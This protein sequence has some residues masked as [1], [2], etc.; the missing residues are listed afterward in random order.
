MVRRV[1]RS[2]PGR[3]RVTAAMRPVVLYSRPGWSW[4]RGSGNLARMRNGFEDELADR[5]ALELSILDD[6][7]IS[8][9]DVLGALAATGLKLVVDDDDEAS[10]AYDEDQVP[11]KA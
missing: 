3:G 10:V 9:M 1:A 7:K 2:S 6:C 4:A 8:G 11:P 5:L